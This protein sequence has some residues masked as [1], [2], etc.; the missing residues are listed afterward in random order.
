MSDDASVQVQASF[1]RC[2]VNEKFFNRFFELFMAS[3]PAI[4]PRFAN[5]VVEKQ[6]DILR[7]G[8]SSALMFSDEESVM[9]RSCIDRIRQSHDHAHMNVDPG[10]YDFWLESLL[11]TVAETDPEFT[12]ALGDLWRDELAPAISYIKAGY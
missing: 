10:L 2:L 8:V 9:A 5:V 6:Y 1:A 11:K 12:P 4:K 7:H 3:H